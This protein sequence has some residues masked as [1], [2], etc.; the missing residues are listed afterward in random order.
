MYVSYMI[1]V[2]S[3]LH[4]LACRTPFP[5]SSSCNSNSGVEN[6]LQSP[7]WFL[8]IPALSVSIGHMILFSSGLFC[9]SSVKCLYGDLYTHLPFSFRIFAHNAGPISM[10]GPKPSS[11]NPFV[12]RV[13]NS[14]V[15]EVY[16]VIPTKLTQMCYVGCFTLHD[17]PWHLSLE[18][19]DM[20]CS[21][22]SHL[23]F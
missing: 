11:Q 7:V 19:K 18:L 20:I 17:C 5:S 6:P 21:A 9:S 3:S 1:G 13:C 16:P 8:M 12:I 14:I 4:S 10:L 22:R 23:H 15:S 2:G